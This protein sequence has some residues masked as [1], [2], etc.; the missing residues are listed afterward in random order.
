[1]FLRPGH[2]LRSYLKPENA[3]SVKCLDAVSGKANL[4]SWCFIVVR[5]D[6]N[7]HRDVYSILFAF[8]KVSSVGIQFTYNRAL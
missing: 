6:G 5:H 3:A 8:F 2:D 1:M 4:P 7:V